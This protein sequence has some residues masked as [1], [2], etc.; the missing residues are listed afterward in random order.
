MEQKASNFKHSS[1]K[2]IINSVIIEVSNKIDSVYRII[3][4]DTRKL[5]SNIAESASIA[6]AISIPFAY[7]LGNCGGSFLELQRKNKSVK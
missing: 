7:A 6:L 5:I 2:G 4:K 3:P 1:Y